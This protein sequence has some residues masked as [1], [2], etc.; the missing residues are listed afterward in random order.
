MVQLAELAAVGIIVGFAAG[1][2]GKLI[3]RSRIVSGE[4]RNLTILAVLMV[5][6]LASEYQSHQSGI[7]AAMVMGFTISAAELPDL[8]SV[9]AFKGQLTIL[10]ISMLFIL[11]AAQLDIAEVVGL[12]WS[13]FFVVAALV[14]IVR[15]VATF[16][17]IFPRHLDF[18]GRTVIALTAPRGIVAAAVASLAA[19]ELSKA[20]MEGSSQIEGLVYL[21][22]LATV[23]WSSVGALLL[24]RVLGYTSD[25]K[26]QRTILV[27]ANAVTEAIAREITSHNRTTVVVDSVS[28]RLD[29]F[30]SGGLMAVAGDARDAITF[31][32]AG[33]ER[34]STVVAATT[35]DELNLLV[36]ELVHGEFGVEHPV[37]AV[38]RPP[39]EL[40]RR[41]RGWIDLLGAGSVDIQKWSRRIENG[42]ADRIALDP[43]DEETRVL[44]H[45]V[46][47]DHRNSVLRMV[48]IIDDEAEFRVG[49]DQLESFDRLIV[50]VAE[51][52]P[53]ELLQPAHQPDQPS[54][55]GS[56]ESTQPDR[57]A[58]KPPDDPTVTP[59][60]NDR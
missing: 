45:S 50:L 55:K 36:A 38:Q 11:L 23:A 6:Y 51:G 56:S 21:T 8:V 20:G 15:P 52:R 19:R 4:L 10:I 24:P 14:L 32:E 25:P 13:G 31:E 54:E 49:D 12:S 33:T 22:I 58:P 30:R 2:L 5:C 3:L 60:A 17:S 43:R 9:K 26:R 28:W 53:L 40:G 37:V 34:D 27:G 18:R 59:S 16:A 35:N 1:A 42:T 29:R 46:E 39:E 7:L 57:I 44:L 41:S 48:G 47:R